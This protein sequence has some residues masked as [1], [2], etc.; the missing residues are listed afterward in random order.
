MRR[1]L[2]HPS[3]YG[4][5]TTWVYRS[6]F[7]VGFEPIQHGNQYQPVFFCL[8]FNVVT[9]FYDPTW[10]GTYEDHVLNKSRLFP[11]RLC[12]FLTTTT[13]ADRA[14]GEW[15][16]YF[17]P[18]FSG[19]FHRI[20]WKTWQ[21]FNRTAMA[22][23]GVSNEIRAGLIGLI[24]RKGTCVDVSWRGHVGSVTFT[25]AHWVPLVSALSALG[26]R[27]WSLSS[28]IDR[29][30]RRCQ[31]PKMARTQRFESRLLC[32][33]VNNTNDPSC[34]LNRPNHGIFIHL[35]QQQNK[36]HVIQPK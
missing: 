35:W 17:Q 16:N 33:V 36:T 23:P 34:W 5:R 6:W 19:W 20:W 30:A 25:I 31:G 9:D 26:L 14:A 24:K 13:V 8:M 21:R 4:S 28:S 27:G 15:V 22:Q 11:S 3:K 2:V 18:S 32:R 7:H 1:V 10:H 12:W 29:C